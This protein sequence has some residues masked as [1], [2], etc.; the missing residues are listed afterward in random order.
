MKNQIKSLILFLVTI[1]S[2]YSCTKETFNEVKPETLIGSNLETIS[3]ERKNSISSN[4]IRTKDQYACVTP[5]G[6][7][8]IKCRYSGG[9]TCP[10][11]HGCIPVGSGRFSNMK[12]E[13][14]IKIR[15][16][17]PFDK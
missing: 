9:N 5:D 1:F 4:N 15:N 17:L 14:F 16:S 12:V 11:A 10:S 8:G 6:E 7:A 3:N 2:M 13:E